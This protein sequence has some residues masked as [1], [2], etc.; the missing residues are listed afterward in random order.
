M[1]KTVKVKMTANQ[2]GV[3]IDILRDWNQDPKRK[4][5]IKIVGE[6]LDKFVW[7]QV[8]GNITEDLWKEFCAQVEIQWPVPIL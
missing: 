3:A 4:D 6:T 5:L 1:P 2:L 7:L 8:S